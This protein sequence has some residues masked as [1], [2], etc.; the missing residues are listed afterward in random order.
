[1]NAVNLRGIILEAAVDENVA[2]QHSATPETLLKR[3]NVHE[4]LRLL[5]ALDIL[6]ASFSTTWKFRTESTPPAAMERMVAW[7]SSS[8]R[9]A[10]LAPRMVL[11]KKPSKP[12][13][14]ACV[15]TNSPT[16][17][18]CRQGSSTWRAFWP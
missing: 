9:M 2:V 4:E 8:M 14:V 15:T 1:L 17:A 5:D 11:M 16:R 13:V 3:S 12:L 7:I 6:A 18:R 10:P